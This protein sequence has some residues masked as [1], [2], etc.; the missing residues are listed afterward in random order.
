MK[1]RCRDSKTIYLS[2]RGTI[3]DRHGLPLAIDT[4]RYDVYIHPDLLRV[5]L[6]QASQLLA[7][8]IHEPQE[9]IKKETHRRLPCS[10]SGKA[11]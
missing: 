5:N 3:T 6:N 9:K 4:T 1:Q 8:I 10:H 2:I 7:K 11:S